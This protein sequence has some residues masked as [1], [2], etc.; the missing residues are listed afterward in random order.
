M[1]SKMGR[2]LYRLA[3]VLL[4]AIAPWPALAAPQQVAAEEPPPASYRL[5]IFPYMAPLQTVE[6]YGPVAASMQAVL[7]TPV[8]L[9]SAPTFPDFTRALVAQSYDIALIQP[10]D[11]PAVVEEAGYLPLARL[12]VPL[13][14]QFYV[15]DDSRYRSLEDLRGTIVAMP[16][17]QSANARMALRALYDNKLVPGRD[18][19]LRYFNSHDS[20]IQQV[21][22]GTA[23][24][25]VTAKPPIEVFERRMQARL[26]QIYETPPIP[27]VVFV[28]HP[29]VPAAQRARLQ[30]LVI[31][32]SQ[33]AEGRAMLKNL[34]FP[35]FVA[36]R[37][38]DYAMMHNYDPAASTLAKA[39]SAAARD[40][41]LGV[42]PFIAPR[43]LAQNFA[44]AQLALGKSIDATVRLR[45]A[46]N[47]DTF[48]AG[49]E[50]AKYDIVVVNPF[51]YARASAHGYL[52]LAGM[53]SKLQGTF[54]VRADSPY[55]QIIDF[56]G[57][58]IAMPPFDSV[59]AR[60]GRLALMQAGLIPGRDVTVDYR[61]NHE[62]CLQEV[63]TGA[64][65]AC[66]T[67]EMTL[68]MLPTAVTQG[69]R[70]VG[71][72][73]SAPGVLFMVHR[74]LPARTRGQLQAEITGWR[75]SEQGRRILQSIHFGD[76]VPVDDAEYRRMP[77]LEGSR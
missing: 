59:Q 45:T 31:G 4:T 73:E 25:C 2:T 72:T 60:L 61:K 32:W 22:A 41:V 42:F 23:S 58:A 64:A 40:L 18:L 26:R 62:S 24:A 8:R 68:P 75:D 27:H 51:D 44:P 7:K 43:Q 56:R 11:Y 6:F 77:R 74:R 20:C 19:E 57:K 15:R 46:T 38:A 55:R 63:R 39:A 1:N 33:T 66:V 14:T 36:P 76:F 50:A 71:R 10:F 48:D 34:G 16:P 49:I 53:K 67:S 69:L 70:A 35:G 47:F 13:V 52:P 3:L 5:G 9:E 28:A 30:A 65:Q 17:A 21:W 12:S 37:Q 54:F 29:R